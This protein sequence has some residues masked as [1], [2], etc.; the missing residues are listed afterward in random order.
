MDANLFLFFFG[1]TGLLL[2]AVVAEDVGIGGR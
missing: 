1:R 2:I